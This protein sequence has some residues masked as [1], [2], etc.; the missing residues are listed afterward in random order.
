MGKKSFVRFLAHSFL[1]CG[2][3]LAW[4]GEGGDDWRETAAKLKNLGRFEAFLPKKF[5]RTQ[6]SSYLCTVLKGN[7]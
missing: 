4:H 2:F 3:L 6:S 7:T 5:A 1:L